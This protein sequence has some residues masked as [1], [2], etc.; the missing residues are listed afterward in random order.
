MKNLAYDP[1]I[2]FFTKSILDPY[3]RAAA[4]PTAWELNKTIFVLEFYKNTDDYFS[5]SS[6]KTSPRGGAGGETRGGATRNFGGSTRQRPT[7][8]LLAPPARGRPKILE[9]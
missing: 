6:R 4:M 7:Q 2:G 3:G 8:P 5:S 9:S 1:E